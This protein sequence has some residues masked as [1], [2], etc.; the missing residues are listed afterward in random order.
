MEAVGPTEESG[1]QDGGWLVRRPLENLLRKD[2]RGSGLTTVRPVS[3]FVSAPSSSKLFC[4]LRI[5]SLAPGW[6]WGEGRCI[7]APRTELLSWDEQPGLFPEVPLKLSD[8]GLSP[9]SGHCRE[10]TWS[11]RARLLRHLGSK[12]LLVETGISLEPW[13]SVLAPTVPFRKESSPF[14]TPSPGFSWT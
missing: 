10:P 2:C 7:W 4:G 5:F 14:L 13:G 12:V 1:R 9:D 8:T 3:T 11:F 6:R